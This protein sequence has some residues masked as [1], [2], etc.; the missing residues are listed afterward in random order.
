[1]E[2]GNRLCRASDCARQG[3]WLNRAV[4][5]ADLITVAFG[6]NDIISGPYG[7]TGHATPEEIEAM[8]GRSLK[9]VPMPAFARF[10]GTL[11]RLT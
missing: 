11:R 8:S 5:G 2:S 6:T 3:N 1:M 4:A 10:C 7:G 9:L